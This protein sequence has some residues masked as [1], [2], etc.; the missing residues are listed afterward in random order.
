[1][2][3]YKSFFSLNSTLKLCESFCAVQVEGSDVAST[4]T[5]GKSPMK[6][7]LKGKFLNCCS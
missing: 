6:R 3:L 7:T 2:N 4:Q 1:M 5:G